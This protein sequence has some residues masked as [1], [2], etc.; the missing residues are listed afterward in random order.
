M[1]HL[2]TDPAQQARN[3]AAAIEKNPYGNYAAVY[4]RDL[5]ALLKNLDLN[6]QSN[7][8]TIHPYNGDYLRCL[9]N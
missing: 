6:N 1:P 4:R 9:I 2:V 5:A 8:D 7:V 3:L